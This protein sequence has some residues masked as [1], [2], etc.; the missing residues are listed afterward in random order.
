MLPGTVAVSVSHCVLYTLSPTRGISINTGI[1][2]AKVMAA[3]E[4]VTTVTLS[5]GIKT[6]SAVV[7][8]R[9][10]KENVV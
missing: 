6:V 4:L 5:K 3:P 8:K 1:L 10:R 9:Y 7:L 2:P